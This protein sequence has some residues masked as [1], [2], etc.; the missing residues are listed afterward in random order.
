MTNMKL[1]PLLLVSSFL[2][3]CNSIEH[4]P[5]TKFVSPV[6]WK[7][8]KACGVVFYAPRSFRENEVRPID[9]C[10]VQYR[11]E[12]SLLTLDAIMTSDPNGTRRN[13]YSGKRDFELKKVTVDGQSAEVITCYDDNS[14]ADYEGL[15]YLAILYVP[16][17]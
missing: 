1:L 16:V 17:L 7:A 8:I 5:K 13:D 11:N 6:D 3:T 9:S 12:N 15:N 4:A 10:V 2:A 14:S